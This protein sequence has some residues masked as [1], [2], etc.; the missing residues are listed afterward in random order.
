METVIVAFEHENTGRKLGEL[1]ESAGVARC[2]FCRSGD[3]VRRLLSEQVVYCAV[4]SPHLTDGPA[5]WLCGDLPPT[6]SLLLVGPEYML[7][8][9]ASPDV[10]K[11]PTP[12]R[13]EEAVYTVRLLLQFG[14]R[15][16]RVL[17]PKRRARDQELVERAK[18][19]LIRRKDYTEGLAHRA[20]QKRSMD[21]GVPLV[22]VAR[23]VLEELGEL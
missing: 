7:D 22:Q 4:C 14:R 8:A 1:L 12:I 21:E 11:L 18:Q 13:R 17:R 16:E 19:A 20:L 3:Q 15:V 6:C 2:L 9:C 10:F 5:E 23:Q